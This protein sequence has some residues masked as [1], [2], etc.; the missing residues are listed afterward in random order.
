MPG[1]DTLWTSAG[2]ALT[3]DHPVELTW[4]NG[5]GLIF[6]RHYR[7]RRRLHVHAHPDGR[8]PTAP[9]PVTLYPYALR[10][11][12]GEVAGVDDLSAA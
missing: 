1:T 6:T 5:A 3:P 10:A 7:G 2:G 11:A 4:D 12:P 8:E 9:A